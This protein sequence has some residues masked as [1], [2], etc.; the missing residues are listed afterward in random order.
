MVAVQVRQGRRGVH[1]LNPHHF[2]LPCI[3]AC[4][5]PRIVYVAICG[6]PRAGR[7]LV[8]YKT[9]RPLMS[10]FQF[11]VLMPA[12]WLLHHPTPTPSITAI[13]HTKIFTTPLVVR[14]VQPEHPSIL[15]LTLSRRRLASRPWFWLWSR[16]YS[17]CF[18]Y[19]L[20]V[21]ISLT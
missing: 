15:C 14:L 17:S 9:F 5:L 1:Y 11:P 6:S 13:T 18:L 8:Q 4:C 7:G 19:L 3:I 16:S 2:H 12:T 10:Q 21:N 20:P